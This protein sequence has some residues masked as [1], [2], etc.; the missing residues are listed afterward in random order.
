MFRN[1]VVLTFP[2]SSKLANVQL[3]IPFSCKFRPGLP[4]M[5]SPSYDDEDSNGEADDVAFDNAEMGDDFGG[6]SGEMYT[7]TVRKTTGASADPSSLTVGDVLRVDTNFETRTPLLLA[8]E[9][10]WISRSN[11]DEGSPGVDDLFLISGGCPINNVS[12]SSTALGNPSFTFAITKS[13]LRLRPSFYLF[14]QIGLCSPPGLGQEGNVG[15]VSTIFFNNRFQLAHR[16]VRLAFTVLD[17]P[18]GLSLFLAAARARGPADH[19]AWT[20]VHEGVRR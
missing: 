1:N 7:M 13:F 12:L 9:S 4:G 11:A 2:P 16:F 19:A 8:I 14:C 17:V 5:E 10:C 15:E 18:F 6:A 20:H 3:K